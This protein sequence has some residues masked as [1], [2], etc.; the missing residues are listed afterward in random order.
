[1]SESTG[2]PTPAPKAL[3]TTNLPQPAPAPAGPSGRWKLLAAAFAVGL[4][5]GGGIGAGTVASLSD[6]TGSE[7]YQS[8]ED[9]LRAAE[10]SGSSAERESAAP[11]ST[12]AASSPRLGRPPDR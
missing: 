6:P 9:E 2:A 1:M 5:V 11:S 8:L 4:V 3:P 10:S 7:E 12:A